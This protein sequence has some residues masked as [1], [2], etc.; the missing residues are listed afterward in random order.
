MPRRRGGL[1]LN[2][3]PLAH[4]LL[5]L[6]LK[7]ILVQKSRVAGALRPVRSCGLVSEARASERSYYRLAIFCAIYSSSLRSSSSALLSKRRSLLR[8]RASLPEVPQAMSSDDFRL[9]RL[10]S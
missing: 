10:G 8:Y 7:S 6:V 2:C 9:G 3:T 5:V 1:H 4:Y